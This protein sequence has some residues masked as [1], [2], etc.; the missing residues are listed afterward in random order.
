VTPP[1]T[2]YALFRDQVSAPI[3][4]ADLLS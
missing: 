2:G 4:A 1:T 3:A